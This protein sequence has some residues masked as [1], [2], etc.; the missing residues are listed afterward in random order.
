LTNPEMSSQDCFNGDQSDE[1]SVPITRR[2]GQ[3]GRSD[4]VFAWKA[5]LPQERRTALRN[6]WTIIAHPLTMTGDKY[7]AQIAHTQHDETIFFRRVL[8]VV[9][10]DGILIELVH[11][12]P[13][14]RRVNQCQYPCRVAVHLVDQAIVLMGD[15]FQR[16]RDYPLSA[17]P[18]MLH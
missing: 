9:E 1:Y 15:E 2:T 18:G 16:T 14:P 10:L 17:Y 4:V 12:R 7:T 13:L 3:S 5:G 8:F 11:G 6:G